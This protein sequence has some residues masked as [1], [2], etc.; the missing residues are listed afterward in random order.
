MNTL[1]NQVQLLGN[2]GNEVDFKKFDSG[3]TV[4]KFSLATN[5]YYKNAKGEKIQETQWHNIV[6]WGKG[7]ELMKELLQ[8]G[9][10]VLIKG[11]LTNRSYEAKDGQT[12]YVTEVVA[13]EFVC[14]D[15]KDMPF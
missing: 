4:A 10:Q 13:S 12:K 9:S 6:A 8:K 15:P 5:D 2:L 7:A 1:R 14:V 3:K 11:R